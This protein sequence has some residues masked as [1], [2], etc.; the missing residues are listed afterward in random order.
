[1]TN[2]QLEPTQTD[3]PIYPRSLVGVFAD[4]YSARKR[5]LFPILWTSV[6]RATL[7]NKSD[8]VAH[9]THFAQVFSVLFLVKIMCVFLKV[10]R[11]IWI[12]YVFLS[13]AGY[14]SS[15]VSP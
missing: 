2:F 15:V 4:P 5:Q 10:H 8:F 13:F 1:M 6:T 9:C 3:I 14:Q 12:P 11:I 7:E